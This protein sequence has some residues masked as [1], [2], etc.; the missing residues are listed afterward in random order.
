MK[1]DLAI[2]NKKNFLNKYGHL[3]P[4]TYDI[5]SKNYKENYNKYFNKKNYEKKASKKKF[6]VNKKIKKSLKKFGIYKDT[7]QLFNFIKESIVYREYAK[8]IFSKSIDYVFENLNNF[9][10]KFGISNDDLAYIKIEKI[11]NMYFNLS[12]YGTINNLKKH[13][14]ENKKEYSSNKNISLPDVIKS[15]KDLYIQI[16]N[17]DK[18]N[19]ISNKI[20]TSKV[21]NYNRNDIKI[22]YDGIVCVENADPGFDFLFNK[23]IKGLITKYGGLNSHMAIRC[24][25]L[26]LPA[27]IGVGEKNYNDIT[28]HK[29]IKINCIEKK[30]DLIN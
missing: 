1:N 11:L 5:T 21:I 19:Y 6:D 2:M 3:R 13:I 26:N 15:S 14:A 29:L 18:I 17:F 16:K 20:I 9:G 23:N 8:F 12:N 7:E 28:K 30:I 22:Y 10:K 24:S 25:E 4:G 27:L